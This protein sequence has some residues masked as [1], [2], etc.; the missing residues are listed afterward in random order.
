MT[1]GSPFYT[2]NGTNAAFSVLGSSTCGNGLVLDSA[3]SC[4]INVQFTPQFIGQTTQQLTVKSDGY[5]G[6]SSAI[7]AP[8]LTLRGTGNTVAK[9][10]L[11][12]VSPC[13]RNAD[14]PRSGCLFFK[15][16]T[17]PKVRVNPRV[18]CKAT[19]FSDPQNS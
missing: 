19:P 6:G 16:F 10:D 5:N 9:K 18:I 7:N 1:L 13:S 4:D 15:S 2:T 12:L 17:D 11:R 3:A 8:I 14:H